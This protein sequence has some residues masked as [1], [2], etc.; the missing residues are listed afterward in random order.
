M[1]NYTQFN[2]YYKNQNNYIPTRYYCEKFA[3]AE[4]TSF[5]VYQKKAGGIRIDTD[6]ISSFTAPETKSNFG[7][8]KI[9][10]DKIK[11]DIKGFSIFTRKGSE[12]IPN[13]SSM[14]VNPAITITKENGVQIINLGR[15]GNFA[16]ATSLGAPNPSA[17]DKNDE[18]LIATVYITY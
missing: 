8:I 7:L 11:S 14:A 18:A 9:S 6:N 12:T 10:A 1:N 3:M 2:D 17:F 13:V 16:M 15:N 4:I 5:D